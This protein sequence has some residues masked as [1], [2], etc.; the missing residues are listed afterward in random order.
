MRT[1]LS[2]I[3]RYRRHLVYLELHHTIRYQGESK[4]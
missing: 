4:I 3:S 1:G 2:V